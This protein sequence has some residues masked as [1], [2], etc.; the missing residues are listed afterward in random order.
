MTS[1]FFDAAADLVLD[2]IEKQDSDD[3]NDPGGLTRFGI[4]LREHPELTR[5]RLLAM[6][7]GD[8][9]AFY[10]ANYW[11]NHRCGEMPWRWA[12]G[13]FDGEVNQGGVVKFAQEALHVS[14]DGVVG[15]GTLAAMQLEGADECFRAF[16]AARLVA[17]SRDRDADLYESG[18]FARVVLIA[19]MGEHPP[20]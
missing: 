2:R 12:L 20:S 17:Y 9:V 11:D 6:T 14:A 8:A 10:R 5:E 18:W 15:V 7:R 3:P 4:A 16:L 13:V 19:Q 1:D